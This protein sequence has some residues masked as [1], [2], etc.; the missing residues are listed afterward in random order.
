MPSTNDSKNQEAM[1]EALDRIKAKLDNTPQRFAEDDDA[2]YFLRWIRD[3]R[4]T[5][6][7]LA[8]PA[9]APVSEGLSATR[10][11]SIRWRGWDRATRQTIG[12]SQSGCGSLTATRPPNPRTQAMSEIDR[13]VEGRVEVPANHP[14]ALALRP[15]PE[16]MERLRLLEQHQAA[17]LVIVRNMPLGEQ[18]CA[19]LIEQEQKR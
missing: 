8:T 7:A 4:H 16:C 13:V 2:E 19:R 12:A 1:R 10:S 14:L 18:V 17:A 5:V 6:N 9:S 15:S 11:F 3:I